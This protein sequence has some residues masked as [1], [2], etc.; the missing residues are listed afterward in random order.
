M[1]VQ[2]SLSTIFLFGVKIVT[3]PLIE[4]QKKEEL[5]KKGLKKCT[6]CGEVKKIS[7]FTK[8]KRMSDG[9]DSWCKQCN[10]EYKQKYRNNPEAYEKEKQKH[11]EWCKRNK[12]H[13]SNYNKNWNSKNQERKRFLKRR[14]HLKHK[15]E[16][17]KKARERTNQWIK[18]NPIHAKELNRRY[19][20]RQLNSEGNHTN[21]EWQELLKTCGNRCVNC[22]TKGDL[23]RDHIIP[24][25]KGGADYIENIQPLCKSCNSSKGVNTT[26]YLNSKSQND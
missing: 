11:R 25:S 24:L 6:K 5:F 2:L 8:K 13:I 15:E 21:E 7:E 3:L 20:I 19:R 12:E 10:K 18:D 23:T 17:N 16:E 9:L 14:W 4:R 1:V 26:D 22:G